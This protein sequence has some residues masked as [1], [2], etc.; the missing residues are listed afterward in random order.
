VARDATRILLGQEGVS[1]H[2]D[3]HIQ[4]HSHVLFKPE[5]PSLCHSAF[6]EEHRPSLPDVG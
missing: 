3:Q 1:L 5:N 4:K 2:L 6:P